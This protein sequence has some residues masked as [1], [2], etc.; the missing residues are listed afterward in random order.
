MAPDPRQKAAMQQSQQQQV[1]LAQAFQQEQIRALQKV[2]TFG[3]YVMCQTQFLLMLERKG[4]NIDPDLQHKWVTLCIE[5]H[6]ADA[7]I[8]KGNDPKAIEHDEPDPPEG[9]AGT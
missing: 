2:E 4:F 7:R 5:I 9:P 1:M 8:T 3:E 6:G